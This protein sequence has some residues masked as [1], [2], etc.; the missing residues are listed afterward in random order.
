MRKMLKEIFKILGIVIAIAIIIIFVLLFV[1]KAE[2]EPVDGKEPE[3]ISIGYE[4]IRDYY[5]E[6][7]EKFGEDVCSGYIF[8]DPGLIDIMA[9]TL[10]DQILMWSVNDNIE[11]KDDFAWITNEL[12]AKQANLAK[13]LAEKKSTRVKYKQ[14]GGN[15]YGKM[16][17]DIYRENKSSIVVVFL[18]EGGKYKSLGSGFVI[19]E[20][21]VIVTNQ[22]VVDITDENNTNKLNEKINIVVGF[23]DNHSVYAV[24]SVIMTDTKKDIALLKLKSDK[25]KFK[26]VTL[27]STNNLTVGEQ[28]YSIGSPLGFSNSFLDGLISGYRINNENK[29]KYLQISIPVDAGNSGGPVFNRSGQVVGIVRGSLNRT[30]SLTNRSINFAIPIEYLLDYIKKLK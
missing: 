16:P 24:E 27:S 21:G 8:N 29:L 22:H 19:S 30:V 23:P 13:L 18:A 20:D 12:P 1:I 6:V 25:N 15:A 14:S 4:L 3:K 9:S 7:T 28:I 26:P 2:Q 10:R 11:Y 5:N 17:Q